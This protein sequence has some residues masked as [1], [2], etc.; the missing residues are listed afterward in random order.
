MAIKEVPKEEWQKN[1]GWPLEDSREAYNGMV[2][3]S[4][5]K[6]R[7]VGEVELKFS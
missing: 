6:T 5:K 1:I 7:G 4:Q 2:Y 3:G